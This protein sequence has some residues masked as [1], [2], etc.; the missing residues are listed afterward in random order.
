MF[1]KR[2]HPLDKTEKN[3]CNKEMIKLVEKYTKQKKPHLILDGMH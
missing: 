2:Q 3:K 1:Q